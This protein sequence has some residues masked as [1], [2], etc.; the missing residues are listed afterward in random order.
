MLERLREH[1]A[2]EHR[3]PAGAAA[4]ET[5]HP[6]AATSE[7]TAPGPTYPR[8]LEQALQAAARLPLLAATFTDD[9]PARSR[10]ILPGLTPE[11][12]QL[13]TWAPILAY[14]LLRDLPWAAEAGQPKNAT[15]HFDRLLLRSALA[16]LF[17]SLGMEGQAR[18]QA[19]A[20]VRL[21]L[22]SASTAPNAIHTTSLFAEPDA[23]WLAGVNQSSGNTWF[24][25][26]QFEELLTW[27]QLPVLLDL[28]AQP[29]PDPAALAHIERSVTAAKAA[30]DRASYNLDAF[31]T[32]AGTNP[33]AQEPPR[34]GAPANQ[35]QTSQPT[36]QAESG[37]PAI[38]NPS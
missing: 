6:S 34:P 8:S 19:A 17:A 28:S 14:I 10:P 29:N 37:E 15:A 30:A 35:M 13:R 36:T 1:A 4:A 20:Q 12:R 38:P 21:L 11:T 25:K 18:W 24:N 31:H 26:E 22:T 2:I 33:A 32:P 27:L 3:H 5:L 23:R 9:W 7:A 16:D